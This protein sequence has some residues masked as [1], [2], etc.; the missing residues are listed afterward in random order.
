MLASGRGSNR[1]HP[2]YSLK[3]YLPSN[4]QYNY[5]E[6]IF[7][8]V[9]FTHIPIQECIPVGCVPSAA[10]A[11]CWRGVSASVHAGIHTLPLGPGHPR[12]WA[13]I[14]PTPWAWTWT[15]PLGRHPQARVWTPPWADTPPPMNRMTDRCKNIT[16]A[17]FVCGR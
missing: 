12:A 9:Y 16:F 13:W 5:S 10:V 1:S 3:Y 17:N 4:S 6:K 7:Y 11:V 2:C 8:F 14:P 15:P